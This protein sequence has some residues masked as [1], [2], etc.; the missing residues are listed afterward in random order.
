MG[1]A[2]RRQGVSGRATEK[3]RGGYMGGMREGRGK[4]VK[5]GREEM[6]V[7]V[8]WRVEQGECIG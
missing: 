2:C 7:A 3:E 8:G 4:V 5:E 1:R 6:G